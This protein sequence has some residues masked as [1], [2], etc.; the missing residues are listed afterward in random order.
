VYKNTID[1]QQKQHNS[2]KTPSRLLQERRHFTTRTP[3]NHHKNIVESPQKRRHFTTRMRIMLLIHYKS[4]VIHYKNAYKHT[5]KMPLSYHVT[6]L[7]TT[8]NHY[9]ITSSQEARKIKEHRRSTVESA[10]T[11]SLHR[12]NAVTSTQERRQITTKRR[13]ITKNAV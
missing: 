1:L 4:A 2:P 12:R 8:L 11:P 10:R 9:A 13:Q 3:Y 5:T 6:L 7:T